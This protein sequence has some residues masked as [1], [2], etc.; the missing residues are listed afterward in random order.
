MGDRRVV[1]KILCV[2][3][4]GLFTFVSFS[5]DVKADSLLHRRGKSIWPDLG[6]TLNEHY[7]GGKAAY[8]IQWN[9]GTLDNVMYTS[10]SDPAITERNKFIAGKIIQDINADGSLTSDQKY[11]YIDRALNTLFK[12]TGYR[13]FSSHSNIVA[14]INN[15]TKYVDE[16]ETLCT[17]NNT[18]GC[19]NYEKFTL[20]Y[21][22]N[23]MNQIGTS[24]DFIS[25]KITLT[26]L[27]SSYGGT[28]TSYTISLSSSN[29]DV[30]ICKNSNGTGC[31]GK[32]VTLT[33]PTSDYSF[34]VKVSNASPSSTVS[35]TAKGS[36]SST[37]P[38]AKPYR[39]TIWY[40][41][42][43]LPTEKSVSRS[44]SRST[45]LHIPDVT[46]YSITATKTDEYGD[47][48]T[49]AS[50]RV[51]RADS[52]GKEIKELAK[53]SSGSATLS[54]TETEFTTNSEWF[55]Y[56]YCLVETSSPIGYIYGTKEKEP[57]CVT[58]NKNKTSVCYDSTGNDT[59][60]KELCEI[61]SVDC[62]SDLGVYDEAT[63]KCLLTNNK[64]ESEGGLIV[65]EVKDANVKDNHSCEG[66]YT[67]NN[68]SMMCELLVTEEVLEDGTCNEG[69]TLNSEDNICEKKDVKEAINN[70]TYYCDEGYYHE[71]DADSGKTF[72]VKFSCGEEGYVYSSE[73]KVCKKASEPNVCKR[74]SD[75]TKV[76]LSYCNINSQEYTLVT[77]GNNS[78]N[79]VKSNS[80]NFVTISKTD[81]TG[82]NEISGAK[83]KICSTKP[84]KN[85]DCE[86]AYVTQKGKCTSEEEK[87][88]LCKNNSD[89]TMNIYM[90]WVSDIAPRTFRGL[91]TGVNYYLVET[92]APLGYA[93]SSY[94]PFMVS[95]DG[96]VTSGDRVVENNRIIIENDLTKIVISKQDIATS[97]E[98]PGATLKLC[99]A[100]IDE[101]GKAITIVDEA[102]NCT[103]PVLADGSEAIWESSDKPKEL[104]GLPAASYYLVE[105]IT[106]DDYDVAEKIFF[107]LN[108]DGSITDINGKSIKDNKIVMYDKKL[109]S[110]P[111]GTTILIA[112]LAG[113]LALGGGTLYYFKKIKPKRG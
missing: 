17:G 21:S 46:K 47:N 1:K 56:Q 86:L 16:V 2:L 79:F 53:N 64:M 26:G 28:S 43:V 37:Y 94:V 101:D 67:Y 78:I 103:I 29:S 33:N 90:Q 60:D 109:K 95:E 73:E 10:F 98:L 85:L 8:C 87:T 36:N 77:T 25:N 63:N 44:L 6:Y 111:T 91:K 12:I 92:I 40:Q 76:D 30:S 97:K 96:S 59:G 41:A 39:Y 66:D 14:Y 48:L 70:P 11:V 88:G 50:F 7:L 69:F 99:L 61:H 62:S 55:D 105:T 5:L 38:Y 31:E 35:V 19:F 104:V 65:K 58:P 71:N 83:M 68:T 84:D 72:C 82:E 113:V 80:K 52:S 15:A 81:V 75:G 18:S 108:Q 57:L 34:Y 89:G 102:G 4:I 42:L 112:V 49:G 107:T 9:Y 54:Y 110:P 100:A 20:S 23:T 22:G 32:S 106:P 3:V 51:Y 13:D 45:T 93:I 24:D 27:L 74:I